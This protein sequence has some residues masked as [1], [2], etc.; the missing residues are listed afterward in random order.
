MIEMKNLVKKYGGKVVFSNFSLSIQQSSIVGL[1]G[2]SGSGKTTLL[3]LIGGLDLPDSGDILVNH[4]KLTKS[5]SELANYRRTYLGIVPQSFALLNFKS[6]FYNIA[7][8]LIGKAGKEEIEKEIE[9]L[10]EKLGIKSLL[11]NRP[12]ELS[13]G[14]RQRVAIAR[15]VITK[16]AVILADEPTSALDETTQSII[17]DLFLQ[18][19]NRGC[20]IIF[21][22]HNKTFGEFADKIIQLP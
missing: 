16:P 20:T 6:A 2:R 17:K 1:Y 12:T 22:S 9:I 5:L 3:N 18:E 13:A 21:S 10:S 8:P 15:A 19:Q 11:T 4:K 7:L 14:E